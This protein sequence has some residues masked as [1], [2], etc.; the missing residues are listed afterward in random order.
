[1]RKSGTENLGLYF[2]LLVRL[3]QSVNW[4]LYLISLFPSFIL[5]LSPSPNPNFLQ[6]YSFVSSS[7]ITSLSGIVIACVWQSGWPWG[8]DREGR[9]PREAQRHWG[10]VVWPNQR[11]GMLAS[12]IRKPWQRQR[13]R[14]RAAVGSHKGP[15]WC[16]WVRFFLP[17]SRSFA[18]LFCVSRKSVYLPITFEERATVGNDK[19]PS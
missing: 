16:L 4:T 11:P 7:L 18:L 15:N 8:F 2:M 5:L 12:P 9:S 14:E 3:S 6:I 13:E 10:I 19:V 17:F 1:M